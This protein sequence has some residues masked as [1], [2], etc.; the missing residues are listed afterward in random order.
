[1]TATVLS[2][3]I[4]YGN[5]TIFFK[6]RFKTISQFII[7]AYLTCTNS[8]IANL[9]VFISHRHSFVVYLRNLKL[10]RQY[11][12]KCVVKN[13]VTLLLRLL[14]TFSFENNVFQIPG[15][16]H[17]IASNFKKVTP[18]VQKTIVLFISHLQ[19]AR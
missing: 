14:F 12:S 9:I 17:F 19:C 6:T 16:S 8:R 13:S 18:V 7:V 5:L 11:F 10:Y 15:C 1:M 2:Q 4:L 3:Q